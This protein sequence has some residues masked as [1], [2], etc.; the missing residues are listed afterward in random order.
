VTSFDRTWNLRSAL[1]RP[2]GRERCTQPG[3]ARRVSIRCA[4][5][6]RKQRVCGTTWCIEHG[7][8]FDDTAYCR[9]HAGTVAALSNGFYQLALPD[10]ENRAPSLV[11]WVSEAL[12]API[13]EALQGAARSLDATLVID[14]VRL[15]SLTGGTP[16]RCWSRAWKLVDHLG[17]VRQVSIEVEEEAQDVVA[18]RV[19]NDLIG[20]SM[21]PWIESRRTAAAVSSDED[22]ASRNAFNLAFARSVQAFLGRDEIASGF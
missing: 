21:P 22:A 1:R 16:Q 18:L 11:G 20:R 15:N 13:R 5:A 8:I 14:P 9:R 2:S 6:D 4:Y 7:A 12:D 17:V 19:D 3:C 10:L